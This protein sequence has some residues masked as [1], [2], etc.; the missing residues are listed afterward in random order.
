[1]GYREV[2]VPLRWSYAV[3]SELIVFVID[4]DASVREALANLMGSAGLRVECF[5]S[6]ADF[7]RRRESESP[8]CLIL[9]VYMPGASGIEL[10]RGLARGERRIPIIFISAHGDIPMA[11]RAIKEGAVEFLTKPFRDEDLLNA[12]WQA[13]DR[14]V[15]TR[16]RRAEFRRICTLYRRLTTRQCEILDL[17]VA[18][19]LN[20]QIAGQLGLSENTVKAHRHHIMEKMGVS[21]VVR[22]AQMIERLLR[23]CP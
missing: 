2:C 17:V 11:V 5:A 19:K 4:D 10:Q 21:S 12:V 1:M 13:L 23:R 3:K 6:S 16:A 15:S 7:L 20:K 18:G 9:D 8:A 22:L 14:D